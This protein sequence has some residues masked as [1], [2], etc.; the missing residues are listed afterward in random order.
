MKRLFPLI[1]VLLLAVLMSPIQAVRAEEGVEISHHQVTYSFADQLHIEVELDPSREVDRVDLILQSPRVPTFLGAMDRAADG[2]WV[3][4]YNLAQRPLPAFAPVTYAFRIGLEDGGE[5]TSESYTFPYLDNRH[6]W[7]QLREA[8]FEIYWYEGEITLAQ[9]VLDAARQ[10]RQQV[11]DLIQQ[12]GDSSQTIRIFIYPSED[13]LQQTLSSTNQSW[14]GGHAAPE[15]GAAVVSLPTG[16][17]QPLEVQRQIPHEITHIVLYRYMGTEYQYLP[18]WV[19]EG[20]ASLM[21]FYPRPEY[22][23]LLE[24]AVEERGLIPLGQLCQAFPADSGLVQLAYAEAD[25]V[26]RYI[27]SE[28]GVRGVQALIAAYDQGVSCGRGVEIAL[29]KSLGRL[30]WEWK[31]SVFFRTRN[32]MLTAGLVGILFLLLAAL[33]VF[34][35]RRWCHQ[36]EQTNGEVHE[37]RQ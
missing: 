11:L 21:E 12:P 36:G 7:Q 28:Y 33:A 5:I 29:G 35:F 32:L 15:L 26:M 31:Q 22:E 34:I 10:G 25:S 2:S 1:P 23:I 18:V 30:E 4:S 6:N 27:R 9:Q 20:I 19:S 17:E 37:R 3:F 24:K 8:P 13:Q 16:V 14:V